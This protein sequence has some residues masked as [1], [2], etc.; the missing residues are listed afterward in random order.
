MLYLGDRL[1]F[2]PQKSKKL[3]FI[4][5]KYCQIFIK[6]QVMIWKKVNLYEL[7]SPRGRPKLFTEHI[8]HLGLKHARAMELYFVASGQFAWPKDAYAQEKVKMTLVIRRKL[9]QL[10]LRIYRISMW[11]FKCLL[12]RDLFSD[13][14]ICSSYIF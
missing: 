4:L 2:I 14:E 7:K 3:S 13:M 11:L 9:I 8:L 1:E 6:I 10:I 5:L 12:N